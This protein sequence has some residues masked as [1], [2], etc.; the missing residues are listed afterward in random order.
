M[1]KLFVACLASFVVLSFIW[2]SVAAEEENSPA[3]K[4]LFDALGM[5]LR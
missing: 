4:I 1:G 3:K 2:N 5:E